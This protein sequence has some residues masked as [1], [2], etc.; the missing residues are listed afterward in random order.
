MAKNAEITRKKTE[1]NLAVLRRFSRAM[2]FTGVL[3]KVREVRYF[4]R[5]ESDFKRKKGALTKIKKRKE[6]ERKDKLGLLMNK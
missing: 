2:K 3:R 5:Q 6:Y 1:N 4:K